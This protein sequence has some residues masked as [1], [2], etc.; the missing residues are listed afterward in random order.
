M[1]G[2]TVFHGGRVAGTVTQ[3]IISA[4]DRDIDVGNGPM[5]LLQTDAAINP[6]NSG[7]PLINMSGQVI[8]INAGKVTTAEQD[9]FT[10][11]DISAEGLGFAIPINLAK[12]V[13]QQLETNGRVGIGITC[14][15]DSDNQYNPSGSPAGI[16]I[17]NIVQG[18]PADTAGLQ[19]ND[20]ILTVD[21]KTMKTVEDLLI[22]IQ[23]HKVGD[24]LELT[25]WRSGQEYKVEVVV[26]DLN[27]MAG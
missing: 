11:E 6:G 15:I 4:I 1:T 25:V 5:S 20:I 19:K 27:S 7:G 3:G 26:G 14:V 24:K 12:P 8:G 9:P 18:G 22:V 2:R 13:I 10:G 23:G 21:G 16:T 17:V